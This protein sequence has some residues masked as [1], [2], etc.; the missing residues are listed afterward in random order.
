[1]MEN[2]MEDYRKAGKITAEALDIARARVSEG[3]SLLELAEEIESFIAKSGARPAFPVNIS[4]NDAAAHFT[5]SSD[6]DAVFKRGDVVKVDC[7]ASIDGCMG[8]S[9]ITIE[10]GTNAFLPLVESSKRALERVIS[11]IRA[12]TKTGNIGEVI[13]REITGFGFRPI[14]NLSGHQIAR[15]SLHAGISIP[16]VAEKISDRIR[17]NMVVA[18]EPF[19][20]NGNGYVVENENGNIYQFSDRR[21]HNAL[22][23]KLADAIRKDAHLSKL[24][25]CERWCVKLGVEIGM[26]IGEVHRAMKVLE[27]SRVL[28]NYPVLREGG[29]GIVSQWEHTL[30]IKDNGCEILTKK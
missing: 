26:G 16:N 1:M 12:D 15:Y 17:E 23:N 8:D 7:G 28:R 13:E 5:P 11:E 22:A 21:V 20:T 6:C 3:Y 19:A 25:L 18:V 14:E 2:N 4:I 29:D 30:F 24:P 27:R 9:A 10:V